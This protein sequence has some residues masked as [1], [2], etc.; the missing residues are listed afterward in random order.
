MSFHLVN[1]FVVTTSY[2]KHLYVVMCTF[3]KKCTNNS[4]SKTIRY[5][6][7]KLF[8]HFTKIYLSLYLVRP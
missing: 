8:I 2:F 3:Y 1:V 5:G 7:K 4:E 6:T